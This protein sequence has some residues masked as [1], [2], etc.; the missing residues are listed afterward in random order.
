MALGSKVNPTL[1]LKALGEPKNV[2]IDDLEHIPIK[3]PQLTTFC[4]NHQISLPRLLQLIWG[5]VL[6]TYT[7]SND[8]SFRCVFPP[9]TANKTAWE[10][11]VC[12]FEMVLDMPVIDLLRDATQNW[13][14]K[15]R[16]HDIEGC[17]TVLFWERGSPGVPC[18]SQD[19]ASNV[20]TMALVGRDNEHWLITI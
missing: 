8:I 7:G 16:S 13:Y 12:H 4:D 11:Y 14:R 5:A 10:D 15:I 9:P 17:D 19:H 1:P 6:R 20:G 18:L 3:L 2:N